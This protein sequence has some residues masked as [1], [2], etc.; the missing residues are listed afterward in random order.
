MNTRRLKLPILIGILLIANLLGEEACADWQAE[1]VACEHALKDSQNLVLEQG[2]QIWNYSD[3][4]DLQKAIIDAK[5]K[6]LAS[7]LKDPVKVAAITAIALTVLVVVT[8]H[9][10]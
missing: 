8:G 10:K 3:Q 9:V 1:A 6:E 7:P 4:S 5:D 2:K